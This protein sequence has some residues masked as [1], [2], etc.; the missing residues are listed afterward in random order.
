MISRVR[1]SKFL[2]M[3][4]VFGLVLTM[5]L[6]T[7]LLGQSAEAARRGY[8]GPTNPPNAKVGTLTITWDYAIAQ[9]CNAYATLAGWEPNTTYTVEYSYSAV[10]RPVSGSQR[11]TTDANGAAFGRI[12]SIYRGFLATFSVNGVTRIGYPDC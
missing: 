6:S 1:C 9:D 7:P 3:L 2:P 10:I 5:A 4:A 12:T 8:D 11:L